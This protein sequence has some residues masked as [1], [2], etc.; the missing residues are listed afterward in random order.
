[1]PP[2]WRRR[3]VTNPALRVAFVDYVLDPEKPGRSGLSDMVWDMATELANLG[4]EPHVVASYHT[5]NY[6]D[7]RVRVH[8]FATP[9]IGYR[10]ILGQFW[11]LKRAA[12]VVRRQH[13][14]IV[15]APEYVSTAVLAALGIRTPLVLTVPGN[16]YHR[17]HTGK[18]EWYP[19]HEVWPL[20]WAART[21]A[22]R[23]AR[24]IAISSEM[25]RWWEW[26]GS[27]PA[28][29]PHIPLGVNSRRFCRIPEARSRLGIEANEP[30][31]LYAGRLTPDKGIG[32][33]LD[34][35]ERIQDV[36]RHHGARVVVIGRG[37]EEV[38]IRQRLNST[39]LDEIVSTRA[40]VPQSELSTWYSAADAVILPS[41]SEGF[42]RT[43]PEAMICGTPIIGTRI[44]GTEDHVHDG[45][46]GL[47]ASPGDVA[48]LADRLAFA[49][50]NH[51]QLRDM[52]DEA[53]R[54]AAQHLTWQV[55]VPR[56]VEEV[57]RPILAEAVS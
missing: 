57:Y 2:P 28:R 36:L 47:L 26:T 31:L 16:I 6:P 40:W 50:Q 21:S 14:D 51:Y 11:I 24:V 35:L 18:R 23:C 25:K 44:T 39:A 15:H 46:D 32:D 7:P 30:M 45:I 9:P 8:N 12:D 56:I 41:R 55:I 43:I 42:S 1:M 22:H 33:F 4:H 13:L 52:G 53:M 38:A 20:K 37:P 17:L 10:N 29:T 27:P 48:S 5:T 54:Y 19:W 3:S 49:V 34:A